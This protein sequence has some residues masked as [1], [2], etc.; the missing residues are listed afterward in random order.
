MVHVHTSPDGQMLRANCAATVDTREKFNAS[1]VGVGN[2]DSLVLVY[3]TLCRGCRRR[4]A[5]ELRRS[6]RSLIGRARGPREPWGW[7]VPP[8]SA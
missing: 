1:G 2:L 6:L 3:V 7:L 4:L 5:P 8:K